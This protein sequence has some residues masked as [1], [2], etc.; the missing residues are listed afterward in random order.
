MIKLSAF[1]DEYGDSIEEQIE[2]LK[3]N[4]IH[5]VELRSIDKKN[6][7]TFSLEEAEG[8]YKK[9]LENDI[10]VWSIGSP[11][12]KVDAT[13]DFDAE[14]NKLRHTCEIAKVFHTDK[15]RMFSFYNAYEY[16]DVVM[17]QL[18][19]MV[20]VAK[21]YNVTLYHENEKAIY[22]D[23]LERVED[24]MNTV[25]GLK[26]IYDP[27]NFI[28]CEQEAD[29]TLEA[30]VSKT[31]YFHIKD[32]DA[33]T[34]Q[35][36]PA[37]EGSAKI[38][39]LIS[40]LDHK[41]Y[42][43]TIEPHLAL[44]FAY[45]LVDN[46]KLNT[47]YLYKD[48]HESFNAAVKG[49]KD[50]LAKAG[51][52][53]CND[54]YIKEGTVK[55]GVIGCGNIGS[56]HIRHF[57]KENEIP[58]GTVVAISDLKPERMQKQIDLYPAH[59]FKCYANGNDLI[60]NADVDAVIVAVPHYDHPVLAIRALKKGINTLV[61]KP[62]GVYTLQVEEMNKVAHESKAL[63][64]MMFNQRTNCVYRKMREMIQNGEIGTIKRV[65]WIITTWY[66]SQSY[67]DSGDWRATWSGE[68]GGVLFNQCPHQ[69]DLLQWVVGM[70]PQSVKSFCHFGKWHDI[71]VEDDVTCYMEYPNGAT[72]VFITSTADAP[73]TNRFEVLGTK[74]KLVCDDGVLTC[75]MNEIDEREFNATYKGGFGQP[76]FKHFVV[77]T[78]GLNYQHPGILR[79]F[80]NAIL[81]KEPLYVD[82][83]EGIHGVELM[84][85]M[86]LSS[87]LDKTITLP[88]DG[89]LY[90]E[91]LKKRIATS[92]RKTT[93]SGSVLDTT[94]SVK[95]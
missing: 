10:K 95:W 32:V 86:L 92:R 59:S 39:K 73:G 56:Q 93:A 15:I 53:E 58:N 4:N 6:V 71:E 20:D 22:G 11:I 85:A 5:L 16:R 30:L 29:K 82:G 68:G 36:V 35:L 7:S 67:Y 46:E 83:T 31:D 90:Y 8:Y 38:S 66:R 52:V 13:S 72:G 34:M 78:D 65:N 3:L 94:N 88:M 14:L 50:E 24:I 64:T 37:G 40:M 26:Y 62:A 51:Y 91:E 89:N 23:S 77:E 2:G 19:K 70:M 9:F 33:S 63:F 75:D 84:D 21:E 47:K 57:I 81:K 48:N 55:F 1:I 42:V 25:N 44:F 80:T 17:S 69:L 60:D 79:N 18:Q 87:W 45:K 54:G 61:E 74:G 76:N 27:A 12:A 49:I 28:Q 43:F 41:D